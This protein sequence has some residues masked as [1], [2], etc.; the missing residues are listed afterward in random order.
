MQTVVVLTSSA[1]LLLNFSIQFQLT[2]VNLHTNY[3]VLQVRKD[4]VGSYS[5]CLHSGTFPASDF[6][7]GTLTIIGAIYR[8]LC[9]INESQLPLH[10][11][12]GNGKVA[13]IDTEGTLYPLKYL[14]LICSVNL[15]TFLYFSKLFP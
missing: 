13:Y 11:H 9:F 3:L 2:C 10:M 8:F 5:L 4:P 14:Y 12:G 15:F 7:D 1:H 6:V